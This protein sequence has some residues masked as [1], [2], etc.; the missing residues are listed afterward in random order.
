MYYVAF[1]YFPILFLIAHLFPKLFSSKNIFIII[2][3]ILILVF[4]IFPLTLNL[5]LLLYYWGGD[6][7]VNMVLLPVAIIVFYVTYAKTIGDKIKAFRKRRG[8]NEAMGLLTDVYVVV[9]LSV[10][11]VELV[12]KIFGIEIH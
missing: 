8:V 6:G 12:N 11:L 3:R 9:F 1:L 2:L 10:M 4:G 5:F 7:L